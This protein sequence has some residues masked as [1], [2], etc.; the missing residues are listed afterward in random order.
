LALV[1]G[2]SGSAAE[3]VAMADANTDLAGIQIPSTHPVFLAV[4]GIHILLGLVC[5]V[6]GI[7]AMLSRSKLAATRA[8][9]RSISGAWSGWSSPRAA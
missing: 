1:K 5:V 2:W 4:V 8:S 3:S 7:I 6:A 9:E